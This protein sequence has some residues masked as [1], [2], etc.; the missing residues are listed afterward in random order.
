MNYV[1]TEIHD[2]VGYI[3]L[4][5]PDK[6]NALNSEFVTEIKEAIHA[7]ELNT[8]TRSIVL[9]S[10]SETFCAGAD[11]AYL[12]QLQSFSFEENLEDS[13]NLA[14]LFNL[15]YQNSKPVI[16]LVKGPAIAGGCGLATICDMCYATPDSTFG[17][18]ESL[19]GF[20][21]AIVLVFLRKKVGESLSKKMVFTGEIF[22][23]EKALKYGLITEINEPDIIDEHVHQSLVR[24]AK[25]S[26]GNSLKAIKML[27][28]NLDNR[29][30]HSALDY[31]CRVNAEVRESEDCKKGIAAFLNKE[32]MTW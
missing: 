25:K 21:P 8:D 12:Q 24:M 1:K 30:I 14:E 9:K 29:D 28:N 7:H 2:R 27:Y 13:K 6:R 16:S 17:Y 31:A 11:L 5:R 10:S 3:I 15:I 19:I 18:T 32:K 20:V 23:A 26:S 22:K 4:N